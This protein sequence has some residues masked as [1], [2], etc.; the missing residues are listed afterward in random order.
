M[1]RFGWQRAVLAIA[2]LIVVMIGVTWLAHKIAYEWIPPSV[3][4]YVAVA[5]ICL[6]AGWLWGDRSARK[7]QRI[8]SR[9][10]AS[11]ADW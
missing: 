4:G 9:R 3:I 8:E 5:M 2:L 6:A 11:P 7:R 10:D 1:S